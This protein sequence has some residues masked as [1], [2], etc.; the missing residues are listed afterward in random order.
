MPLNLCFSPFLAR[1]KYFYDLKCTYLE[2]A[3]QELSKRYITCGIIQVFI[4]L[5]KN[6]QKRV[7]IRQN[8]TSY[9]HDI[10]YIVLKAFD[11]LISDMYFLNYKNH[12]FVT[13]I[14]FK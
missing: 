5:P 1:K 8:P 13:K 3:R 11:E 4:F 9:K 2:S 14:G 10:S 12:F 6:D 7:K